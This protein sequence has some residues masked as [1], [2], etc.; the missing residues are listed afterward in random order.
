LEHGRTCYVEVVDRAVDKEIELGGIVFSDLETPPQFEAKPDSTDAQLE[1]ERDALPKPPPSIFALISRDEDPKDIRVHIRGS[2]E[3]LGD[4][5]PRGFLKAVNNQAPAIDPHHSGRLELAEWIASP[6]NPLTARVFVNRVWKHHFGAGL[7]KSVD[8]FGRMG[9]APS[10]VELLDFLAKAFIDSGWD[11]KWLHRTMLTSKYYRG[12]L[13][14]RRLEAEAI[15]DSLLAVAGNLD[16]KLYGPSIIP[17]ISEYQDGRGKPKSGPLDG[18]ARRSIYVNVRRNFLTPMFL[19][20]DYPLPISTI[21]GRGSSTVPSQALMMMNNEFVANQAKL[22]AER[23]SREQ[24]DEAKRI[25]QLYN[26]AFGRDPNASE[27]KETL[28]FARE[29]TWASLCHVLFNTAEFLY[30][31]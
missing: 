19:A 16:R 22:W 9:E 2:H 5:A 23:A 26:E 12:A 3:N 13:P 18:A 24:P 11:I 30:V 31:Q 8:N 7:V 27:A 29:N 10:N 6:Q 28:V 4:V 1:R 25:V 14:V 21:G 15:R 17:F 20:F